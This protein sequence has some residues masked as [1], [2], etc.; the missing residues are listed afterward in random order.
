[1]N[2][3]K[4]ERVLADGLAGFDLVPPVSQLFQPIEGR[5]G[6]FH[7]KQSAA[8]EADERRSAF[9]LRSPPHQQIRILVS[10]RLQG[11]RGTLG[12][13]QRHDRRSVPE[14]HRPSRR[15]SI[16]ESTADAPAVG[17]AELKTAAGATVRRGRST[18][19]RTSRD[20][21]PLCLLSS[22]PV[23]GSRRATGRP[24][25]T[26]NTGSPPLRPSIKAL[27]LFLVW[28]MLALFIRLK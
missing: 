20:S 9:H 12:H 24:R 28:V 8:L 10:Q 11:S 1:M 7:I 27:R 3:K 22:P 21:L 15:S 2:T 4:S 5:S 19:S 13:Q 25:S 6:P 18:P 14:F 23:T 26:I 16:S 17:G